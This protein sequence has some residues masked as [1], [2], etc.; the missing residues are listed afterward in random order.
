MNNSSE[1]LDHENFLIF[2]AARSGLA[3][4]RLLRSRGKRVALFDEAPPGK[5]AAAADAAR[6]LGVPFYRGLAE[7]DFPGAW[8]V[9]VL[10][11]GIPTTHPFVQS[12]QASGCVVRSEIEIAFA[13]CPA[14]IAAITGT[15][16]KTTVTHLVTHLLRH[17][18]RP[19]V[20]GGNV[21]RALS[22]AV[23]DPEA[24]RDGAVVVCE[25]SSFQ[26][27]TIERFAPRVACVLNI[28]PD[29]QD[30][31]GAMTNYIDAKRR[32]TEN[33]TPEDVLVLNAEDRHC[34][35]FQAQTQAQVLLFS[36]RRPMPKGF[37]LEAGVI[38]MRLTAGAAPRD[39]MLRADI[40]LPG[41]HNVENV[42]AALAIGAAMGLEPEVMADAVRRFQPVPHRIELVGEIDGVRYYN[43][44]KGTNLDSV[45]K[46]LQSFEEPAEPGGAAPRRRIVLIAG[47]RD[48]GA[49]WAS[50]GRL[51]A[52][53]VRALVTIGE[54]APL[55]REAWAPL[56]GE[57]R[58][59]PDMAEALAAARAL[60]EPGDVVLLSPGCASF[61][62]YANYEERGDHFR[63]LVREMAA[64]DPCPSRPRL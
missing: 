29:H 52:R 15:N 59:A 6:S 30:R 43:D 10:S 42:L 57:T 62:M 28:T 18:G 51:V 48:K 56:V 60:A 61:D 35:S 12:A 26:L 21:G 34:R 53:T 4:A 16:G 33:Q 5:T 46:A 32:V 11:P 19:A 27:E 37:W 45:E 47:G 55:V 8:Q 63:A 36:S 50:L 13:A 23:T 49:R 14:P 38:R 7:F 54:A 40:P 17:A 58:D 44:S 64:A 2:G 22:D 41:L 39:V 3:A 31:Y 9:V 24:A 25:V 1:I 20:M